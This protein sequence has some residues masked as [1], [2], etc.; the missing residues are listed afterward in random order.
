MQGDLYPLDYFAQCR[1]G[2]MYVS[3]ELGS[4]VGTA[5]VESVQY[6]RVLGLLLSLSP[7]ELP[8]LVEKSTRLNTDD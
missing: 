2:G 5:D 4:P 6:D 1:N 8:N 7:E 3:H